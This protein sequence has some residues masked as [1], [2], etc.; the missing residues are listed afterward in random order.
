[1]P[2]HDRDPLDL[3]DLFYFCLIITLLWSL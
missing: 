1:M 2:D 3:I